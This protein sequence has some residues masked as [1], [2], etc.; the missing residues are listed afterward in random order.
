MYF[1]KFLALSAITT[2]A[3]ATAIV[4]RTGGGSVG[5]G[6]CPGIQCCE[7]ITKGTDPAVVAIIMGIILITEKV[8]FGLNCSPITIIGGNGT[9][10]STAAYCEDN[11]RGGLISIGCLPI[12]I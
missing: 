9:C 10:S 4:K 3:A 7:T 1:N 2:L 12:A 11:S 6:S 8:L 5:E